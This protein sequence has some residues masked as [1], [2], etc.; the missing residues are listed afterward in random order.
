MNENLNLPIIT[1]R[2][3]I[4]MPRLSDIDS[5]HAAKVEIWRDL[6]EWMNWTSD[7]EY[8]LEASSKFIEANLAPNIDEHG[9]KDLMLFGVDRATG[10]FVISTGVHRVKDKVDEYSTGY[11]VTKDYQGKGLATEA[12][13]AVCRYAFNVLGAKAM[14]ITYF[15]TNEKSCRVIE[16]MGFEHVE[17]KP[18][19]MKC[20]LDGRMMDE[21]CFILRDPSALPK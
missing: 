5:M 3:E 11:W 8:S 10:D 16:K 4:R 1:S 12:T 18:N 2:L 9:I 19:H 14:H 20:H 21:H 7:E 15:D 6:Q 17:T 13:I